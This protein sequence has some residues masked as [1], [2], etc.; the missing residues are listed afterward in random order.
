MSQRE[1]DIKSKQRKCL[2][3]Q[4]ET[5]KDR[6]CGKEDKKE[7]EKVKIFIGMEKKQRDV[8]VQCEREKEK[9][10]LIY[11]LNFLF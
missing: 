2:K 6:H 11:Q 9:D 10:R 5:Q 8:V 3:D 1:R 4:K 7:R